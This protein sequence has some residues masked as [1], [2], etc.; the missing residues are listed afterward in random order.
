MVVSDTDEL[1]PRSVSAA[2]SLGVRRA[3]WRRLDG[4]VTQI[5]GAVVCIGR[6]GVTIGG[7]IDIS[8]G[9]KH[10]GRGETNQKQFFKAQIEHTSCNPLIYND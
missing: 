7:G 6:V 1:S 2:R 10:Y 9:P 4:P 3:Q 5:V 8:P